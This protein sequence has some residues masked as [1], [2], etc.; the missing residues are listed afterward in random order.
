MEGRAD[1]TGYALLVADGAKLLECCGNPDDRAG[2]IG[3]LVCQS[4]SL[5]AAV[6]SVKS[7]ALDAP[8]TWIASASM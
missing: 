4:G 2:Q 7:S 1:A 3:L 6:E 5:Q 8:H